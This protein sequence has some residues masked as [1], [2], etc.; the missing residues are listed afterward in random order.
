MRDL[1]ANFLFFK[2]IQETYS[3]Y[4]PILTTTLFNFIFPEHEGKS[5]PFSCDFPNCG[6][7][8]DR[9]S[10]LRYHVER[11]HENVVNFTCEVCH[12]GF[13]KESDFNLH[14]DRH[15]GNKKYKCSECDKGFTHVSNLNRHKRVHT[16]M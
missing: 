3:R 2:N 8:F 5:H 16:G 6:L 15:T 7:R 4:D 10:Q 12:K 14:T 9:K 11:N 1:P 13:Y